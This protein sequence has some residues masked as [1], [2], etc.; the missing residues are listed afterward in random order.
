MEAAVARIDAVLTE[1]QPGGIIGSGKLSRELGLLGKT[2]LSARGV[3]KA[4][5]IELLKGAGPAGLTVKQIATEFKA[6]PGNLHVWFSSTGRK[7]KGI[8]KIAPATYAWVE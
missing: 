2:A 6:K 5:I 7:V 3:L 1:Y 8:K 4:A